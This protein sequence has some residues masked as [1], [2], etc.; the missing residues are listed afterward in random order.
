MTWAATNPHSPGRPAASLLSLLDAAAAP[1]TPSSASHRAAPEAAPVAGLRAE[2][3]RCTFSSNDPE[4]PFAVWALRSADAAALGGDFTAKGDFAAWGEPGDVVR[5]SG[6]WVDDPRYGLQFAAE[7]LVPD[8]PEPGSV[9]GLAAWL[10]RCKGIGRATAALV[11]AAVGEGGI[12]AFADDAAALGRALGA[13]PSRYHEP[14]RAASARAREDRGRARVLAWCLGHGLGQ[15]RSQVVWEALGGGAI[16]RITQDP[17]SLADLDGFGFRLADGV[18]AALGVHPLGASRLRAAVVHAVREAAAEEG[19]VYLP[20]GEVVRRADA[21]LRDIAAKTG[22]GRGSEGALPAGLARAMAVATTGVAGGLVSED[23]GRRI[24][25]PWLREAEAAVREWFDA[26]RSDAE[27]GLAPED[28]AAA[29]AARSGVR[30]ALDDV[31]LAAVAGALSRRVSVL[32]GPPGTGKTTVTRAVL[33]AAGLLGVAAA[34]CLLTA[35][36][37]RAAKRMAEVTGRPAQTIHRLLEYNPALGWGRNADCPLDGR[38][39]IV[40]EASMIDMALMARLLSAVPPRMSVL[41]V[42]DADQLPPVGPGAPFHHLCSG[43]TLPVARLERIY[44]TD[45]GGAVARAAREIGAGRVPSAIPGD[46]AYRD[47]VFP[48]A[49]RGTPDAQREAFGRRVRGQM[50]ARLVDEVR[51]LL[52]AGVSAD[53]VQ[54]LTPLRKGPLGVSALN[55]RLRDVLNPA[56]DRAGVFRSKSGRE[57][58]VGDRVVHGRNDY[59]KGIFNGE[60]GRVAAVN[61]P[62][63]IPGQER[64]HQGFEVEYADG[65]GVRRVPY[66]SRDCGDLS[67][68]FASTVHKAQGGEYPHVVFAV[69]WDAYKLLDRCLVYTAVSRARD[70]LF[71]VRE[72]GALERAAAN[73][74][75]TRRYQWLE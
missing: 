57:F 14:L 53:D 44:R 7:A 60:I 33:A 43:G 23:G 39:L 47:A 18:A 32:T 55:D 20:G 24:Y 71:V 12:D 11:A 9:A 45:A 52:A 30:G 69:A 46:P 35:P 74:T 75:E 10:E 15:A 38:L 70:G 61:V 25:L 58:R 37:G 5:L 4:R 68:A 54:V 40:D 62:V 3:L 13:V 50:A 66:W 6:R 56:G 22:Y 49:P 8:L 48:R 73:G 21:D 1:V 41:F 26:A 31:Q 19:H 67:L 64:A 59:G 28:R 34:G 29:V 51:R 17:W 36:T 65:E 27:A 42:G 2:L 72:A 16:D 63:R